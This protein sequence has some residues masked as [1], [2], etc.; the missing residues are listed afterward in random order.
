MR[1]S[2]LVDT[3]T[4]RDPQTIA[5]LA[6]DPRLD[7]VF[8]PL[9]PVV[10]RWLAR[11]LRT[12][13][14]DQGCRLPAM[15]AREDPVRDAAAAV[16][17]AAFAR[18]LGA[19]ELAPLLRWLEGGAEPA[20]G[21]VV[22]DLIARRFGDTGAADRASW[23][24]AQ[25]FHRAAQATPPERMIWAMQ[26]GIEAI[27][28]RLGRLV[29]DAPAGIHGVG[30][31]AQNIHRGLLRMQ[32]LLREPGAV[33][34]LSPAAATARC[35]PAPPRVLRQA[36]AAGQRGAVSW[37]QGTLVVFALEAARRCGPDDAT[38]FMA[39][40]WSACPAAGW[41]RALFETLWV[42]AGAARQG[43]AA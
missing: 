9:G 39:G 43:A 25:R 11:R 19:E 13:F 29:G 15:A 38:V 18:P 17:R 42:E 23:Q 26:G 37:R 28:R 41:V 24:A 27:R 5:V 6:S 31:A 3:L 35:L 1:V 20:L 4:V 2:G 7:R 30:I 22:Q 16:I 8:A 10:N 36:T 32:A 33:R 34:R 21:P 40:S 14:T 12:D